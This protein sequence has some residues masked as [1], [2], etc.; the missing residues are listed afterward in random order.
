MEPAPTIRRL[1]ASDPTLISA[2][3]AE[4]GWAKPVEQY[5]RYLA[6]Q[7]AGRRLTLVAEVG[8]AI[9]GYVTLNWDPAY[10]PFRE[11]GLPEVQDLNVL[12]PFQ[13][14]GLGAALVR[15]AEGAARGRSEAVGIGVGLGPDYGAAQRLYV[16]L[17]YVPDGRGVAYADRVVEPGERVVVDDDLVLHLTKV[18]AAEPP[19]G[20]RRRA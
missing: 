15:A 3:F 5:E 11:A 4:V 9:A 16:R 18:L 19:A 20:R 1:A 2:A 8:G 10:P 6:E 14:R 7:G 17:G 12:P 13:R